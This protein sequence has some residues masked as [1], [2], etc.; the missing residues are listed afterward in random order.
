MFYFK[1]FSVEEL[2]LGHSFNVRVCVCFPK[3]LCVSNIYYYFFLL[4]EHQREKPAPA[5]SRGSS[6]SSKKR[7]N[8]DFG[9][10]LIKGTHNGGYNRIMN[11]SINC[12]CYKAYR[13]ISVMCFL[14]CVWMFLFGL[15]LGVEVCVC[16]R[17]F[18]TSNSNVRVIRTCGYGLV[19]VIWHTNTNTINTPI[20]AYSDKI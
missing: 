3:S 8:S 16:V 18:F 5:N 1:Q 12:C 11:T 20:L 6:S 15:N 9:F 10:S 2:S 13:I 4:S 14:H 17:L 7:T 19:I